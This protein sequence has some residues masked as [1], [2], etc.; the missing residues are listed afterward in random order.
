M[1]RK[2]TNGTCHLL[3]SSLVSWH[4]KKQAYVALSTIEVEYIAA[5]NCYAQIRWM[6]QQLEDYN[7]FL[8]HIP[9]KCDNIIAINLTK[10]SIMNSR[11]NT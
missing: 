9:P 4:S 2:S 6:K 7:I 3:G 1:D 5:E 10:N 8:Y 11:K